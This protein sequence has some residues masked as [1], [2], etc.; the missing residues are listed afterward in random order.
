MKKLTLTQPEVEELIDLYEVEIDRAQRRIAVLKSQL[1]KLKKET[2]PDVSSNTVTQKKRGPKPK[3]KP[4]V[5][6]EAKKRGRKPNAVVEEAAEPKT[7]GRKPVVKEEKKA[8]AKKRGRKPKVKEPKKRGPKPRKSLRK[9]IKSSKGENKVKWNSFIIDTITSNDAL[10]SANTLTQ[11][12]MAKLEIP[13]SE[14]NRVRMAIST[15]LTKMVKKDKSVIPYNQNGNR[16]AFY[17]LPSW[18][19]NEILK[20]E[21]QAKLA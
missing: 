18:F 10:L 17:G 1:K 19:E 16:A 7:K 12:A 9:P 3:V 20:A 8:E 2:T 21:Y 6:K 14:K 13:Q 5:V 11:A 15:A 4:D